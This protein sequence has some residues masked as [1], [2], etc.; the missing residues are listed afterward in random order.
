MG[1]VGAFNGQSVYFAAVWYILCHLGYFFPFLVYCTEKNLATPV[2][3][4]G[5]LSN[6]CDSKQ[7]DYEK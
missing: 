1:D 6:G 2:C 7:S 5:C 3:S 4:I